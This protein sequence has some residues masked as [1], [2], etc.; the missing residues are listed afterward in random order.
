[1]KR[2]WL[3]VVLALVLGDVAWAEK[4]T[5]LYLTVTK[6]SV[7]S[8]AQTDTT[9]WDP[10]ADFRFILQG[11]LV[12]SDRAASFELEVSNVDVVPPMVVPSDGCVPFG[13]TEAPIYVGA[14]DAVLTYTTAFTGYT[15]TAAGA[16]SVMVW[17]WE[18][19]F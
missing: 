10:P 2:G 14:T 8:G 15:N 18:D 5:N 7:S 1:M 4:P 3:V 6:T 11:G 16:V 12:C 19:K 17:G 13:G 9:L